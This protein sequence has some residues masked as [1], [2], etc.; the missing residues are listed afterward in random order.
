MV[1]SFLLGMILVEL[2]DLGSKYILDQGK[3]VL[4]FTFLRYISLVNFLLKNDPAIYSKFMLFL[5]SVLPVF[6]VVRFPVSYKYA[7]YFANRC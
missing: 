2:L 3:F 6:Q 4:K 5:F 1:L 7:Y